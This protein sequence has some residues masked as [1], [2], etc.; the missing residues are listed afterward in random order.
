[1]KRLAPV[2]FGLL[3]A[4]CAIPASRPQLA[5]K[6]APDLALVGA[7]APD[8]DPAWWRAFG[9]PQ[10]DRIVSGRDRAGSPTLADGRLSR[11]TA[12]AGD[13]IGATARVRRR[14]T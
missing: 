4:G 12:G 13:L 2:A 11:V 8:I 5:A 14:P 6:T 3:L 10:L 9:D 7:P 1:M